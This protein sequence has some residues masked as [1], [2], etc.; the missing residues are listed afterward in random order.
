MPYKDPEAQRAYWRR[1]RRMYRRKYIVQ[2]R[3][4]FFKGK[5][6]ALCQT[7]NNLLLHHRD[8]K[9][10]EGQNIWEWSEERRQKEI[11]K[12]MVFCQSCH[13]AVHTAMRN[14]DDPTSVYPGVEYCNK[15][16]NGKTFGARIKHDG[17]RI[18]LGAF[19]TPRAAFHAYQE[20]AQR[21]QGRMPRRIDLAILVQEAGNVS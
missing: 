6:C 1:Y 15:N 14:P 9:T 16:R 17:R 2:R 19:Q 8:P 11:A 20:A 12:C 10:K 7:S 13:I 18:W 3:A 4:D 21:L 5:I